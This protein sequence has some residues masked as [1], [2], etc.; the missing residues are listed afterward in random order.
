VVIPDVIYEGEGQRP[1]HLSAPRLLFTSNFDGPLAP[2]LEHLRTRLGEHADAIWGRCR[3]YPGRD[4]A[5]K[6]ADWFR[7][8]QLRSELFFAAYGQ[9]TVSEVQTNLELR[10]R[11]IDFAL[12]AQGLPPAELAAR[13]RETFP[14]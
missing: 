7:A 8:H 14:L 5:A 12:D 3:A 6:F 1:D 2:Y 13:F 11:L 9:Q 4:D 10:A